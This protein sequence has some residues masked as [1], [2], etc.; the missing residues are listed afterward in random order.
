M[1]SHDKYRKWKDWRAETFGEY[2]REDAVYFSSELKRAGYNSVHGLRILEIGFGHG[3]FAGFVVSQGAAYIGIEID[4]RQV[5][6]ATARGY[7]ATIQALPEFAKHEHSGIDL[8]VAFDVLEHLTLLELHQT[9]D[10]TK[11]LLRPAG[12]LLARMPSGDSPFGRAIF[13]GDL[14]HRITLGSSAVEQIAAEHEFEVCYIAKPSLPLVGNGI[15]KFWRRL[16][17]STIQDAVTSLLNILYHEG[18]PKILTS[19]LVFVLKKKSDA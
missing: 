17:L 3:S 11:S 5:A 12:R 10:A 15:F 16:L 19:N 1:N 9:L 7:V 13:Y 2:S 8:I 14:T 4:A 6:V 18:R